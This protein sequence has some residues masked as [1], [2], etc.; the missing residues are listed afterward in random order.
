MSNLKT[1]K[2]FDSK[3]AAEAG[4]KSR[5]SVSL[6]TALKN[7]F[8][9]EIKKNGNITPDKFVRMCAAHGMKGNSA[10]AKLI[11]EY[12]DGKVKDQLELTGEDGKPI[13]NK[14][15]IEFVNGN[16]K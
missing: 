13:E 4:K 16:D 3:R 7:M 6:K 14:I 9:E 12:I 1:L 15:K 11:F 10:M 5:R 2:P 8:I